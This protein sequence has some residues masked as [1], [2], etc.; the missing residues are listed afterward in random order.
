[1]GPDRRGVDPSESENVST[2]S[3][4]M[5]RQPAS[6]GERRLSRGLIGLLLIA[7]TVAAP[8]Y[9]HVWSTAAFFI[10]AFAGTTGTMDALAA[11]LLFSL[12]QIDGSRALLAT[13]VAY[14]INAVLIGPYALTFP[15][16]VDAHG[17]IGNEQSAAWLWLVWH[18]TFALIV[19]AGTLMA[20][21]I[22]A[23]AHRASHIAL[24]L[25]GCILF[26]A[27]AT[28]AV[29]A[30][31]AALPQLVHHGSF[32]LFFTLLS[33]TATAANIVAVLVLLRVEAELSRLSVWLMAAL[34]AAALDTGLNTISPVRFSLTWYVGKLETFVSAGIVLVALLAAWSALYARS[35]VLATRLNRTL[36][37][38]RRLQDRLTREHEIAA[39][40]QHAS[41][42][43]VLPALD[44]IA[45]HATYRPA[46][47]DLQIG[48]DW[49]D[50]FVMPD[51]RL[52]ITIGDIAGHGLAASIIMSKLRQSL[53]LAAHLS[54]DP[55]A[56]L[57]VAD[58][59]LRTEHPETIAT[60]FVALLERSS[61]ELRWASAGHPPPMLRRR[62]GS[63]F[64]LDRP[65]PPLGIFDADAVPAS[66]TF[67]EPATL[68]VAYTDGLVESGKDLIGGLALLRRVLTD[69]AIVSAADPATSL[70]ETLVG[71]NACDDVSVITLAYSQA[72]VAN[73][74]RYAGQAPPSTRI[75]PLADDFAAGAGR[76]TLHRG[77]RPADPATS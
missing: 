37:D 71:T 24:S 72:T 20:R 13:A 16:V 55:N 17:F 69:A 45:L 41:L 36:A 46:L 23:P 64:E 59:A 10:P 3:S 52:A 67:L 11:A 19:A 26:A 54:P 7:S 25:V 34:M 30:G 8:L 47:S 77:A 49:Y 63:I 61:G 15:G 1:M 4:S 74:S 68:L 44:G 50:A 2:E 66:V 39:A 32:S 60:A 12:Y 6:I 31:R 42:P 43:S 27:C 48:G 18:G 76:S 58:T 35:T 73:G 22:D 51:G 56:M 29:T 14:S 38:S 9:R 40:L 5:L 21:R 53:R 33:L 57:A 70:F 28:L 65:A 62:D 75:P